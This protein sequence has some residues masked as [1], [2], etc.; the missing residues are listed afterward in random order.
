MAFALIKNMTNVGC[1]RHETK[2]VLFEKPFSFFRSTVCEDIAGCGH[3]DSATLEFGELKNMESLCNIKQIFTH[4]GKCTSDVCQLSL[5]SI[6]LR[7]QCL[8]KAVN[9]VRADWR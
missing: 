8:D 6:S 2:K 9:Q 4:M 3:L 1:D 7:G 5:S